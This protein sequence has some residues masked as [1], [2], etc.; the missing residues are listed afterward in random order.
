MTSSCAAKDRQ[1]SAADGLG[2][3]ILTACEARTVTL[4][5]IEQPV[6]SRLLA[7]GTGGDLVHPL[8]QLAQPAPQAG[9]GGR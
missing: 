8:L 7:L 1:G 4:I 5:G 2:R 9:R 6:L 3:Q